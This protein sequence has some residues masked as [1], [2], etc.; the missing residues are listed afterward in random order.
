MARYFR[1]TLATLVSLYLSLCML[2]FCIQRSMLYHPTPDSPAAPE[3]ISTLASG[4]ATLKLSIRP[5]KTDNAIIY[6]GGNS[7]AVSQSLDKYANAFP[8][9]AVYMPHYRGYSG[10]SGEPAEA[11]LHEDAEKLYQYV[12]TRHG[13]IT[14]IGRSLGSGVA[15]RLAATKEIERLVL[16]T[17]YDSILNVAK[18]K[19]PF[20]PVE[21]MLIDRFESWRYAPQV[22]APTVILAAD[23]DEIIPLE[24]T[25]ALYDSFK[26]GIASFKVIK[27]ADHVN[28]SHKSEYFPAMQN[29]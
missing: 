11:A 29:F 27:D 1:M 14:V 22:K 5:M 9:H 19:Y 23:N 17:P 7:E 25:K 8:G 12:K 16:I 24:N 6:F 4:D 28:I 3:K 2:V 18:L 10:S 20:L 21:W 15:I 13:N 26:A